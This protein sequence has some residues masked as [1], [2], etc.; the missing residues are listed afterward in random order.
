MLR[1]ESFVI[2]Y[3]CFIVDF[4]DSFEEL[5][6]ELIYNFLESFSAI[7]AL[8]SYEKYIFFINISIY[9]RLQD[10]WILITEDDLYLTSDEL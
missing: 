6:L 10:D 9:K 4:Y 2:Q 3:V 8:V 1:Q 5:K 7:H